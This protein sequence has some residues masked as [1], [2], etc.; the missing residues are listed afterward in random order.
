MVKRRAVALIAV[1]CLG[2]GVVACKPTVRASVL[3]LGDSI[4]VLSADD[5]VTWWQARD[6]GY[7]PTINSLNGIGA[8]PS[9]QGPDLY[10]PGRVDSIRTKMEP[11]AVI[12]ELGTN[13][14]Q[15]NHTA[16]IDDYINVAMSPIVDRL[17]A[18]PVFWLTVREDVN[19]PLSA[20]L[21][22]KLREATKRWPNLTILDYDA[23][24]RPNCGQWCD[25]VHP[26]AAGQ[27]EYARWLAGALDSRFPVPTTTSTTTTSTTT[28]STTTT[29]TQP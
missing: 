27:V 2:L 26:N 6:F 19:P 25:G 18:V 13:D 15:N 17:P 23:H 3:V 7:L 10:W 29:T 5:I 12:V 22:A 21:N 9:A 24:F 11:E 14:V 28:T 1:M 16:C 4:T 8:C 20:T